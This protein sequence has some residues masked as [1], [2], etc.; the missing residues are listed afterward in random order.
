MSRRR[1]VGASGAQLGALM[2][3]LAGVLGSCASSAP[4]P[5]AP[6]ER[7]PEMPMR[8]G[9]NVAVWA[10]RASSLD[11]ARAL[12]AARP[13]PEGDAALM[14][15]WE[16]NGLR[17]L[18]VGVGELPRVR[19]ALRDAGQREQRHIAPSARWTV[20]HR[21]PP[22]GP[23]RL[24]LDS[25]PLEVDRGAIRLLARSWAEPAIL[26]EAGER[27]L[28]GALRVHLL[29]QYV[30]LRRSE[31]LELEPALEDPVGEGLVL[32]RLELDLR[33]SPGLAYL[34]VP[35]DPG[36]DWG[37]LLESRAGPDDESREPAA[38]R[39]GPQHTVEFPTGPPVP[40]D[41]TVG[42]AL[43]APRT[44]AQPAMEARLIIVLAPRAPETASLLGREA[45]SPP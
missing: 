12:A 22:T 29:F 11:L 41:P 10:V 7:A 39:D 2:C 36:V 4:A 1:R 3:A 31:G 40:T 34:I 18:A 21:G 13:P 9:L 23:G 24:L 42:E 38:E 28:R 37:T 33:A 20:L 25:G 17:L 44:Y 45:N 8:T 6:A 16:A 32:R 19:A 35:E 5:E 27:R 14:A 15:R 43:L 30:E 26:S